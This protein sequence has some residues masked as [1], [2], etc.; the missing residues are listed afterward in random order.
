MC[1]KICRKSGSVVFD[2]ITRTLPI[3]GETVFIRLAK[4]Q[5]RPIP[6]EQDAGVF[7]VCKPCLDFLS[8]TEKQELAFEQNLKV[9]WQFLGDPEEQDIKP[10]LLADPLAD[11][12]SLLVETEL[13]AEGYGDFGEDARTSPKKT[14]KSKSSAQKRRSTPPSYSSAKRDRRSVAQ[15]TMAK[16]Q[17]LQDED[18][19]LDSDDDEE[20]EE[21]DVVENG[22]NLDQ[23]D[24]T[25][26]NF[27]LSSFDRRLPEQ[28]TACAP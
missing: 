17:A 26:L 27:R 10:D 15:N 12:P 11:N 3:S 19:P 28:D 16:I 6:S 9:L 14:S 8:E 21:E 23:L 20:E 18:D 22:E 5:N 2:G 24:N 25:I 13:K 1:C 4:W 7:P